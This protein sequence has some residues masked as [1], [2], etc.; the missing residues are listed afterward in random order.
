[1][2][3]IK[4]LE[5][6]GRTLT[7]ETGRMAKQADGSVTVRYGDTMVLVT[8]VAAD[9]PREGIDF[10][11][12]TVEY[13]EQAYAAGRIPGGFFKR[14]GRPRDKEILSAR[15]IDRPLRPLFPEDFR[16]E[17]QVVCY[18]ISADQE[19]DADVLGMVGA[20]TALAISDIPFNGPIAAVRVGQVDGKLLIN[21][22]FQQLENS[23]LD[24]VVCGSKESITMIEAGARE[25]SED[26][27]ADAIDF[28]HNEI[29]RIIEVQEEL[30][31]ECGKPK[32]EI[33]PLEI[34]RALEGKVKE[35][36]LERI[37]QANVLPKKEH[38]QDA[39]KRIVE[40]T[41]EAL[42]AEY[43]DHQKII[44]Y[45][46][47]DIQSTDLRQRILNENRR[48]DGRAMDEIRPITCELSVLP[49]THGSALFTRG[50]TQSLAVVTLGTG[51]DEQLMEELE[52]EYYKSYMLHYNFPPF[53]V[54]EVKPIRGPGRREIGHGA[55]AE[56]AVAPMIPS[57][58]IFPYTVRVVSDILESNGSSS[59]ASVCGASLALM[60][61]GVPIKAPV[62]GIAMGLVMEG[63]K[64]AILS[65]IMG[66]EDHLGDMDFKVA[67]SR[68]G[69]TALQLDI[70]VQGLTREILK[71]ALDQA[72][73]GRM[74]ILDIMEKAI[75]R[76]RAEL[77]DYAPRILSLMIP[78][79]K[80][81][82]VIGPGGKMIRGLQDEFKCKIDVDEDNSG[83]I[84]VAS[85]GLE[86]VAGAQACVE[87][88]KAMTAEPEIGRIYKD[89]RVVKIMNFGA[90][91][92]FMPGQEGLVH[93]SEMDRKRVNKVE[94]VIKEGDRIDVKL[95]G[96]DPDNGKV[97]L[98][99]KQAMDS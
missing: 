1:M 69:I 98:S 13:R 93:I 48:A 47:E 4:K 50:E 8:A 88:I 22:T 5:L 20:S 59:M 86:G 89:A 80:I 3:I 52:G 14:E 70:K 19:N 94:D 73:A 62:A 17:V 29:K 96:I 18:V 36:T 37:R 92:E 41:V 64:T 58:D 40:E 38:R 84:R 87:R 12:L 82:M 63:E 45:M 79:E 9:E 24:V 6:G 91:V 90:F 27:I 53:S 55:L 26:E 72:H 56:R 34:D 21:P 33:K 66:L 54:G 2:A 23:R 42:S 74:H 57:E 85:I 7:I 10:F 39:I 43:P 81:G 68:A 25:V 97:K 67:G 95:I 49:R 46:I 30:V 28:A 76:P 99:R 31:R 83:R 16:N 65:D 35:L 11:P 51:E 77:S 32:R 75:S 15:M 71:R 60:D 61:A 78:P 44:R